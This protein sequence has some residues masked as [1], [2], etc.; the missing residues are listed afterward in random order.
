MKNKFWGTDIIIILLVIITLIFSGLIAWLHP[1]LIM[2]SIAGVI[3]L[4]I[5]I[6]MNTH[7]I[8]NAIHGV[9][10][11][12]GKQAARRDLGSH[13]ACDGDLAVGSRGLQALHVA[14]LGV[15]VQEF[16]VAE[17]RED[18]LDHFGQDKLT[19]FSNN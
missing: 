8:R 14:G 12:S 7:A 3:S 18:Q 6:S 2:V 15:V 10:F 11:G 19:H 13:G 1:E 5:I 4:I 16:V 17:F 9:F